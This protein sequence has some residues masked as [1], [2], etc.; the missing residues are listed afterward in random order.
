MFP[1]LFVLGVKNLVKLVHFEM[2]SDTGTNSPSILLVQAAGKSSKMVAF[3][4]VRQDAV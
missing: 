1:Q 2:Q 3:K 4:K